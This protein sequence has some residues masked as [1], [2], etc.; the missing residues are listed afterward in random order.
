M[1]AKG[2]NL[3]QMMPNTSSC[4]V[5]CRPV[6]DLFPSIVVMH[7][8]SYLVWMPPDRMMLSVRATLAWHLGSTR[9]CKQHYPT[10]TSLG[11]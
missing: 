9:S 10:D 7:I 1:T 2:I 8:L 11:R 5:G 4:W 3:K 6:L